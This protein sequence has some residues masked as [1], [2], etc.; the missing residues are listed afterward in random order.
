MSGLVLGSHVLA[1]QLRALLDRNPSPPPFARV[2]T[3]SR[4][5]TADKSEAVD[6]YE[7]F[8]QFTSSPA[9]QRTESVQYAL[10]SASSSSDH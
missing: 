2:G 8:E 1:V 7:T 4:L 5:G 3:D 10:I 9:D 6:M